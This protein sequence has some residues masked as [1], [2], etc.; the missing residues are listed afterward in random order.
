MPS[1]ALTFSK[2]LSTLMV[3]DM[4]RAGDGYWSSANVDY[5]VLMEILKD[6]C[7]SKSVSK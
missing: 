6:E 5:E 4:S 2:M 3:N 1:S 7:G